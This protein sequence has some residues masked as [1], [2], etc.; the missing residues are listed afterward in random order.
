VERDQ[1]GMCGMMKA[2]EIPEG[3]TFVEAFGVSPTW[4]EEEQVGTLAFETADSQELKLSFSVI[5]GSVRISWST[6]GVRKLEAFR[7]GASRMRIESA[8]GRT[9]ICVEFEFEGGFSVLDVQ[10]FPDFSVTD[11][12]LLR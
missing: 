9:S 5:A 12:F 11:R 6:Q 3:Q 2:F 10:I 1:I 8:V 7:E 4:S